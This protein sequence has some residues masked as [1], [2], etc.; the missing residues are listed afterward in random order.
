MDYIFLAFNMSTVFSPTD[1]AILSWRVKILMMGQALLSLIVLVVL[2]SWAI[3][4][5]AAT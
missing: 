5:F 2:V 3:N 4:T 1:I